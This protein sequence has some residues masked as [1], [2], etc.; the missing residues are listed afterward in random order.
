MSKSLKNFITIQDALKR[1]SSR[2][3]RIF[4]L[5]HQWRETLD[6]SDSAMEEAAHYEKMLREFFLNVKD[7]LRTGPASAGVSTDYFQ[8]W[9]PAEMELNAKFVDAKGRVRAALCDNIDTKT[10]LEAI[11]SILSASNKYLAQMKQSANR[12][13][14]KSVAEYVTRLFRIF[15]VIEGKQELGFPSSDASGQGSAVD[16]E[17]AL[18]PVLQAL[19]EFREDVRKEARQL[20]ASRVL[21]LCDQLRDDVLPN[22][23]VRMEDRE[24]QPAALKLVPREQLLKERE[25]KKLA[26]EAKRLEKERKKAELAAK[27]A[28][29]EAKRRIPPQELFKSMIHECLFQCISSLITILVRIAG[30]TDKYSAFDEKGMPTLDKDGKEVSKGQLKKLEKLWQAQEK[31][32]TA[33]LLESGQKNE[34]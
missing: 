4:F 34:S 31:L 6:Y 29:K 19:A 32:Y 27:E 22:L 23:G 15:G 21:D 28:E 5:L 9:G 12:V 3:L 1:N 26:E 14:M 2:E 20:K 13:L 17:E 11:R 8:K 7:L 10:S 30:E 18:M 25:E 24:N 16:T 33:Y